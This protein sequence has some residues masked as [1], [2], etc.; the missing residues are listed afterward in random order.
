MQSVIVLQEHSWGAYLHWE[1]LNLQ[2]RYTSN[3]VMHGQCHVRPM[4]IFP[5]TG[6]QSSL[7]FGKK[8]HQIILLDI[9]VCNEYEQLAQSPRR[10]KLYSRS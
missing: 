8:S 6:H 4:L 7:P 10:P 1:S 3:S 2:V 5:A 9:H